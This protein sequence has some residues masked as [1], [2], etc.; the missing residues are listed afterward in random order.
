MDE[1]EHKGRS[2]PLVSVVIPT[3]NRV[4]YCRA[5]VRSA[6][7]QTYRPV[8]VVV[9]DDGSTDETPEVFASARDPV[10]YVRQANSERAA[11]RNRGVA[12][13]KGDYVAFLDSDDFWEPRH[14]E[15]SVEL[16]A[17]HPRA[18]LAFGRAV[19][20]TER[21]T[22]VRE[23]PSPDLKRGLVESSASIAAISRDFIPF[24]LSSVVARREILLEKRF[25]E[26]GLL[27]R[28]EDW[29]L[30]AHIAA[31]HPVVA[32]GYPSTFLRMHEGN[33]SQDADRTGTAMRRALELALEDPITAEALEPYRSSI[34]SAME[35][36][37]GRLYAI[38]GRKDEARRVLGALKRSGEQSLDRRALRRLEVMV[39]LPT[40]VVGAVRYVS[41][42]ADI[43]RGYPAR[44]RLL[45]ELRGIGVTPGPV[46]RSVP[47]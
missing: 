27:Q 24:P 40:P 34:E 35:L 28:S 11:A 9:V 10:V 19:Y 14:I 47:H 12:E 39:R 6:I 37:I 20:T 4:E 13:A 36:Q 32:T 30:W 45:R 17:A 29:E 41:R 25:N 46:S 18:A 22:P 7:A 26:D 44:R 5:A 33:T 38:C 2:R 3:Y 1:I 21:G 43:V 8:E 23:A 42:I 31:R 16:L 15:R